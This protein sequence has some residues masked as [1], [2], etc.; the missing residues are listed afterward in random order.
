MQ[1]RLE[2]LKLQPRRLCLTVEIVDFQVVLVLEQQVVQDP[3]P[4]LPG[5]GLGGFG[6]LLR[7]RMLVDEWKMP[8]HQAELMFEALA[9]PLGSDKRLAAERTLEIA[10]GNQGHR[11][12]IRAT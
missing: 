7:K 5:G 2:P 1:V 4:P 11:R 3:K 12:R 9:E 10:I 6:R 8:I